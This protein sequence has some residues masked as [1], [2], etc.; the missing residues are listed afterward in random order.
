MV[1]R[2]LWTV[3]PENTLVLYFSYPDKSLTQE[4]VRWLVPRFG[5]D[6]LREVNIRHVVKARNKAVRELVLKAPSHVTDVVFMDR[7]IRPSEFSDH[8]LTLDSDIAGCGYDLGDQCYWAQPKTF[9]IGLCRIRRSVFE[10]I[11]PPWFMQT[12]QPDGCELDDCEC[13]WLLKKAHAAGFTTSHGGW[14]EHD[15]NGSWGH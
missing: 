15:C 2:S 13:M 11:E 10:R 1:D 3:N 7:D 6:L 12:F 14:A 5:L 8:F 9:H 4:A